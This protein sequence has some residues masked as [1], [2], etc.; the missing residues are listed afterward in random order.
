MPLKV[1]HLNCATLNP[2]IGQMVCHCLLIESPEGLILVD[3]GL[4]TKDIEYPKKRL[5]KTF[6]SFVKP[7]LEMQETA[8]SQIQKMGY[9]ADDIKHIVL[10]HLHAD[11]AGGLSDFPKAKIH[12]LR[13]EYNNVFNS[14]KPLPGYS[15]QRFKHE[16]NWCIHDIYGEKWNGFNKSNILDKNEEILLVPLRGHTSGHCGV[17]IL[18]DKGWL[19]HCGDAYYHRDTIKKNPSQTPFGI[20]LIQYFIDFNSDDRR[21]NQNRLQQFYNANKDQVRF[22]CSHDPIEFNAC[23]N[24]NNP[25]HC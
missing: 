4:G 14:E 18:T 8:L 1:H 20:R 15:L 5:D 9:V 17:A 12:I 7:K 23:I 22:I 11:H 19:F 25:N 2:L 13:Y 21:K 10:T 16:I 24:G 6:R 3:T